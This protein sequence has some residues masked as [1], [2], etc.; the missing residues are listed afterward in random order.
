MPVFLALAV[1][2]GNALEI[3]LDVF[4]AQADDLDDAHAGTIHEQGHELMDSVEMGQDALDFVRAHDG[5]LTD[6]ALGADDITEVSRISAKD[7]S[8][9]EDERTERLVLST[10]GDVCVQGQVGKECRD[11]RG[12]HGVGVAHVVETDKSH[13]PLAVSMFCTNRVVAQSD[14]ATELIEKLGLSRRG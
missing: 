2:N 8:I 11:F 13:N 6:G 12:A 10:G 1:A 3:E 7:M 14:L 5:R 4:D 9:E